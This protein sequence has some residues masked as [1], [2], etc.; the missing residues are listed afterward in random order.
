MNHKFQEA[1]LRRF[2]NYLKRN[3]LKCERLYAELS[4]DLEPVYERE[5]E[6]SQSVFFLPIMELPQIF[7]KDWYYSENYMPV[8]KADKEEQTITSII[9]YFGINEDIFNHLFVMGR[10]S[11]ELYGGLLL[12]DT[13]T[14]GDLAHNI[15]ALVKQMRYYKTITENE[16]SI[17]ICLN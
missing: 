9:E 15:E 3:N 14:V 17:L 2:A 11:N 13:P 10:Q 16:F 4:K 8:C 6:D 5:D 12:S 7:K 1:R